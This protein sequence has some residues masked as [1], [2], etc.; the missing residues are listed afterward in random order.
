MF[1]LEEWCKENGIP[2]DFFERYEHW[3]EE[4]YGKIRYQVINF[5]GKEDLMNKLDFITPDRILCK[6][7]WMFEDV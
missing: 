5:S 2:F 1:N 3:A 4:G 6:N 7:I